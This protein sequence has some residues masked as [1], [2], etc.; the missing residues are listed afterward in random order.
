MSTLP[1][2]KMAASTRG[3]TLLS[4][5][6]RCFLQ[7]RYLSVNCSL[8]AGGK[9]RE[10]HGLARN[11]THDYGPLVDL[12]DWTYEDGRPAPQTERQRYNLERRRK[13]AER[14]DVFARELVQAKKEHAAKQEEIQITEENVKKSRLR[15]KGT[16]WKTKKDTA[17]MS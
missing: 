4:V 7:R 12:P 9:W 16:P 15:P 13:I 5:C 14:I 10:R 3:T 11:P 6:T 2:Y 8:F 17:E 1:C